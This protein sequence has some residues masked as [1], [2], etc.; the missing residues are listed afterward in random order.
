V[1]AKARKKDPL[2]P[3]KRQKAEADAEQDL[4]LQIRQAVTAAYAIPEG[5][6]LI[7]HIVECCRSPGPV[8]DAYVLAHRQRSAASFDM[9][10]AGLEAKYA[11]KRKQKKR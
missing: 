11:G 2:K 3:R 7:R 6:A 1:A 4:A 9:M 10:M 8:Q 5:S